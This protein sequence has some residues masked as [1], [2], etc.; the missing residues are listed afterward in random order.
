MLQTLWFFIKIIAL[1]AGLIWVAY[2]PGEMNLQLFGYNIALPTGVFLLLSILLLTFSVSIYRVIK[3]VFLI[4]SKIIQKQ[5][6]KKHQK[7]FSALTRGLTAIAAGDSKQA[8]FYAG[9][10]QTMLP[11]NKIGLQLLLEAQ[12]AKMRGDSGLAQSRFE[13]LMKDDD[14]AFLGI[15]G[16]LKA[17]MDKENYLLALDY[18][19]QAY[20]LHPKQPWIIQTLYYLQIKNQLWDAAIETGKKAVKHQALEEEKVISDRIAIYL[21]KYDEHTKQSEEAEALKNI[22]KAYT[23][24]P[25]FSPTI[26]RYVDYY[27]SHNKEKKS[28]SLIKKAWQSNPH[29]DLA[30]LW[31]QLSPSNKEDKNKILKWYQKL[32]D[33]NPD[34]L[35]SH[36][37][38]ANAAIQLELWG[39]AKGA[40]IRAE[41]IEPCARIYR[42][43]AKL[44]EHV[45]HNEFKV[46]ELMDRAAGATHDKV[47]I[48]EQTSIIYEEWLPLALPHKSFNSIV[49]Q[50]PSR[51]R[52][53]QPANALPANQEL[54][55]DPAA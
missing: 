36:I 6:N 2:I 14:A 54:L 31:Q 15:R 55:I 43:R 7:G 27:R 23:L 11:Q 37:A 8:S 32:V 38:Y 24:N 47:W 9:Q 34:H 19:E 44:E 39:D 28:V 1:L 10:A 35:E 3:S 52:G 25:N 18:A 17:A 51:S 20:K 4:P 42:L 49:W 50:Y 13:E 46:H 5:E 41:K 40:L 30:D 53:Y 12:A 45:S 26:L 22:K 48:C 21:L 16:L 33:L 29:P